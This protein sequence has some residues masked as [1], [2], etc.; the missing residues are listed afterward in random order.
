MTTT[1]QDIWT[2]G[3][4]VRI[5]R[6]RTKGWKMPPNTVYVGRP[7]EWEIRSRSVFTAMPRNVPHL[8]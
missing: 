7:T 4:P 6:K 3:R 5:Q 2:E 1:W 8:S